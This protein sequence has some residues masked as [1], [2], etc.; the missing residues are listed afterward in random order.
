MPLREFLCPDGTKIPTG[1][2]LKE[3][4]C[5]CGDRCATRSYLQM[6]ASERPLKWKCPCCKHEVIEEKK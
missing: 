1:D 3:S 4:G 2:C 5:R 6:V